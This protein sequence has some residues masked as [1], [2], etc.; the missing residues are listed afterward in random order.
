MTTIIALLSL[1][2][3]VFW[4]AFEY[5]RC[6]C[7][8]LDILN[9]Q[10]RADLDDAQREADRYRTSN[11]HLIREAETLAI[12]LAYSERMASYY[13]S[14]KQRRKDAAVTVVLASGL[15]RPGKRMMVREGAAP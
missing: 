9:A 8:N 15:C 7:A 3:V 5:Y 13:R 14:H 11:G 6:R 1:S 2:L 12:D 10:L 4:C